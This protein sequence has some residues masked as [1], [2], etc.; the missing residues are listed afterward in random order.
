MRTLSVFP[1]WI[2]GDL[3]KM[4]LGIELVEDIIRYRLRGDVA[5][6]KASYSTIDSFRGV[7]VFLRVMDGVIKKDM[8]IKMMAEAVLQGRGVGHIPWV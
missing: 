7:I 1:P 3:N 4:G 8:E 6:L 2:I 5:P